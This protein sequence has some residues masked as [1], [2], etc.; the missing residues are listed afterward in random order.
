MTLTRRNL[1]RNALGLG[2]AAVA[3]SV[4]AIRALAAPVEPLLAPSKTV[5]DAAAFYCP[6]VPLTSTGVFMGAPTPTEFVTR[7]GITSGFE[8]FSK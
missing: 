2:G 8:N 3:A 7:Y 1:L 4:P 6:Y 5:F